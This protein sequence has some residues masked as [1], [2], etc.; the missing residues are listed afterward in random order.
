MAREF[1]GTID[2]DIRQ[3]TPDWE[4]YLQPVAP[5]G[6]PNVLYSA[7]A[8]LSGTPAASR[9]SRIRQPITKRAC[10]GLTTHSPADRCPLRQHRSALILCKSVPV[11]HC[12]SEKDK[13][14]AY[15]PLTHHRPHR[16][17]RPA[18]RR[19]DPHRHPA[20][21]RCHRHRRHRQRPRRDHP[22]RERHRLWHGRHGHRNGRGRDRLPGLRRAGHRQVRP[23]PDLGPRPRQGRHHRLLRQH[24]QLRPG[25]AA[26]HQ[27]PARRSSAIAWYSARTGSTAYQGGT[28]SW[29]R[30]PVQRKDRRSGARPPIG[31]ELNG[32]RLAM[33]AHPGEPEPAEGRPGVLWNPRGAVRPRRSRQ[34]RR[35]LLGH[36]RNGAIGRQAPLLHQ[37]P[38][39]GLAELPSLASTWTR[40]PP[41]TRPGLLDP[42]SQ[43]ATSARYAAESRTGSTWSS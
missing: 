35:L 18:R 17:D 20:R 1:R 6:A 7:A 16:R 38:R 25:R 29:P 39:L 31:L 33:V 36:Q 21:E 19:R 41:L 32:G 12:S 10:A 11:R 23:Q 4:P 8:R 14:H 15:R 9:S 3:S 30:R 5:E 2:I 13:H 40:V 42:S 27:Q 34:R 24:R 26:V 22:I 37:L 43:S 28:A